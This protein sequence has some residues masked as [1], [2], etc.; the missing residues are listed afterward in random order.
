MRM[1]DVQAEK[2]LS[3]GTTMRGHSSAVDGEIKN[4]ALDTSSDLF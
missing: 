2:V 1:C 3:Q 4:D